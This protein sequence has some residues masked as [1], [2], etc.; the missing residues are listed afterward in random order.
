MN[1]DLQ[2]PHSSRTLDEQ[3]TR[4]SATSVSNFYGNLDTLTE[5]PWE[6]HVTLFFFVRV[7]LTK[8]KSVTCNSHGF[9]ASLISPTKLYRLGSHTQISRVFTRSICSSSI[10]Q[11]DWNCAVRFWRNGFLLACVNYQVW[12]LWTTCFPSSQLYLE[13]VCQVLVMSSVSRKVSQLKIGPFCNT[14]W[15]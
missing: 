4:T 3:W 1:G 5:N 14:S 11:L 6:L 13:H 10:P 12:L 9:D 15:R 2:N 8:K 7:T